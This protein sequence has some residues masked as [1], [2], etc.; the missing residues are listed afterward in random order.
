MN[1]IWSREFARIGIMLAVALALGLL[2]GYVLGFLLFGVSAYLIA[3]LLN[4]YRLEQWLNEGRR[5]HPPEAGGIWGEIFHQFFRMQRR[6]R[7]RKQ[8]LAQLLREFRNSTAAM[9]D[10]TVV[11]DRDWEIIWFN[12]AAERL[13]G[14]SAKDVGQRISNLVRNPEFTRY[15]ASPA[16]KEPIDMTA[17]VD[18]GKRLVLH[19][20]PYG[21]GHRLLLVRDATRLH[22]LEQMRREFVAN[23]SHE[24]RSPL[25]VIGG[26]LEIG[27][28][29]V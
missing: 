14:L 13:L 18:A 6:N 11:L 12:D 25:T 17:P 23:A 2:T 24:L 26:Y 1:S 21:E 20:V 28:A 19:V 3:H 16:W 29:H 10:G 22:R 15:I 8:R 27:R 7:Q 5:A 4:L 9:P